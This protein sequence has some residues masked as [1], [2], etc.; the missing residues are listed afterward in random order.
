MAL[1]LEAP[2]IRLPRRESNAN[3]HLPA[4]HS[5]GI[6]TVIHSMFFIYVYVGGGPKIESYILS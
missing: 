6:S 4:K 2:D 3:L 5:L 1:R